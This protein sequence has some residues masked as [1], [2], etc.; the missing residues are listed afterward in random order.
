[1]GVTMTEVKDYLEYWLSRK[2]SDLQ[3]EH[4]G[5]VASM[6]VRPP[7]LHMTRGDQYTLQAALNAEKAGMQVELETRQ[8]E[9]G[10]LT[11][12]LGETEVLR[13]QLEKAQEL[14]QVKDT[15]LGMA[16]EVYKGRDQHGACRER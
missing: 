8:L 16:K 2:T 1:M 6:K 4:E 7:V 11:G 13:H 12:R 15:K 10:S 3:K 5:Q 14:I 9:I